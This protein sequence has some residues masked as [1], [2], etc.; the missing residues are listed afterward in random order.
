MCMKDDYIKWCNGE[1]LMKY[2]QFLEKEQAKL[3]NADDL[4]KYENV[5]EEE[6]ERYLKNEISLSDLVD[7]YCFS[8]YWHSTEEDS[9]II[10]DRGF[11]EFEKFFTTPNGESIIAFGYF[12]NDY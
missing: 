1:L 10:Q 8:D 5:S 2:G 3:E 12:G 7:T 11:E 4:K 9:S 6:I